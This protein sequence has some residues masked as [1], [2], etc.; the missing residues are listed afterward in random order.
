MSMNK[1]ITPRPLSQ[2]QS[3][4]LRALPAALERA[5]LRAQ[6]LARQTQTCLVVQRDGQMIQLKVN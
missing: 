5:F 3:A 2:A 1:P 6:A 4:D